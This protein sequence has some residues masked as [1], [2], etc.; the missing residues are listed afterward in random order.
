[1]YKFHVSSSSHIRGVDEISRTAR[2]S[3]QDDM[4]VDG[5]ERETP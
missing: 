5:K 4:R 2:I 1:M 3:A